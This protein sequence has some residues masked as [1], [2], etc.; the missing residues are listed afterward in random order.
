VTRH[1]VALLFSLSFF[2]DIRSAIV[3]RVFEKPRITLSLPA[4]IP[5]ETVQIHYF[6]SGSF[7]GNGAGV[8][9]PPNQSTYTIEA[10]ADGETPTD[11]RIMVYAPDCRIVVFQLKVSA[12]TAEERKI[13]C[14]R[15]PVIKLSGQIVPKD[16]AQS[17]RSQLSIHYV[18]PWANQFFGIKDGPLTEFSLATVSPND[19]GWFE[20]ELPD[21]SGEQ[22]GDS[23]RKEAALRLELWQSTSTDRGAI[24]LSPAQPEFAVFPHFLKILPFYPRSLEFTGKSTE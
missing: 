13:A 11:I 15:L 19:Q 5:S 6:M 22:E 23:S 20:V 24:D 7:G 4:G 10:P 2:P 1:L 12:D 14:E 9:P 21:F 18:A 8:T 3:P 16:L 17:G